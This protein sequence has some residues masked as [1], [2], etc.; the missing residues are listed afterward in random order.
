MAEICRRVGDEAQRLGFPRPSYVHVRRVL[1]VQR[2]RQEADRLRREAVRGIV[3]DVAEDL[4]C[5]RRVDTYEIAD[6][7]RRAGAG[8]EPIP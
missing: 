4:M 6:R 5:G 7:L 2:Q 8:A 3:V 1:K